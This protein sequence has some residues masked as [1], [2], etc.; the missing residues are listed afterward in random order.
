M[1]KVLI[2]D[3]GSQY[4]QLIARRIRELHVYSEIHPFN[5]SP[6]EIRK[7]AP[8]AIVL[9]GGPSSVLAPGAPTLP[10]EIFDWGIPILGICYGLQLTAHLL[11]GHVLPSDKR[12]YGRA[13]LKVKGAGDLLQGV[14]ESSVVWMSHGDRVES[15]PKDFEILGE[16]ENT[17]FC[18]IAD[19]AR[20]I[21]GVQFHPEVVHTA[22]GKTIL[23]NFL[24]KV[25]G[26]QA[27]WNM[28][29][30]LDEEKAR[31]RQQVGQGKVICGLSGGV[32]STVAAVLIHEGFDRHRASA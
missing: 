3:F 31:I 32:D 19:Q 5:Y 15:I 21:Y 30:F 28:A 26:L 12:E 25:S 10:K 16:S 29:S 18:A 17:P 24:F 8:Q 9:S 4:T 6:E 7:F 22:A 13:S 11:G 2:L 1:D 23:E 14:P 20:K 27:D